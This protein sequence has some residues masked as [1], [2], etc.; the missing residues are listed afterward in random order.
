MTDSAVNTIVLPDTGRRC[1][2]EL[3]DRAARLGPEY[4]PGLSSHLPMALT[5]LAAIGADDARLQRFFDHASAR[6][7]PARAPVVPRTLGAGWWGRRGQI[8]AFDELVA[9]FAAALATD[10]TDRVLRASLVPLLD[11]VGAAAFHGL[12]RV[13]YAAQ[14]GQPQELAAALAYWACRWLKLPRPDERA[15][16]TMPIDAW[17]ERLLSASTLP[18][19]PGVMITGR[20]AGIVGCTDYA[21]LVG[22]L[23]PA[24]DR[25]GAADQLA[26]LAA[27]A[28]ERYRASRNFTVLHMVTG[29]QAL[30]GIWP[31]LA[32]PA[33]A[34]TRFADAFAAAYLVSGIPP[35]SARLP[36]PGLDW[37]EILARARRCD[38]DHVIK[39]VHSCRAEAAVYGDDRYLHAAGL[40]VT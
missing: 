24:A 19:P 27:F 8:E 15:P 1:L 25:T 37:P 10:G 36:A 9:H 12:I 23:R 18:Q 33:G 28:V 22:R 26:Q 3:L 2:A 30:R 11:G 32:D 34:V 20:M 13:A 31:S 29:A 6:F 5:A 7:G 21:S 16:G 14:A 40:A 35:G 38:D 4:G 39:F 17:T